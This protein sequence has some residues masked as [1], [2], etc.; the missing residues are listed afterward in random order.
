MGLGVSAMDF[1]EAAIP[2]R[3]LNVLDPKGSQAKTVT[4]ITLNAWRSHVFLWFC[5]NQQGTSGKL[6]PYRLQSMVRRE[7][8]QH[9]DGGGYRRRRKAEDENDTD[10][11]EE[12]G[13]GGKHYPSPLLM[14]VPLLLLC[15]VQL[16]RYSYTDVEQLSQQVL[17]LSPTSLHPYPSCVLRLGLRISSH[18]SSVVNLFLF[19]LSFIGPVLIDLN[20]LLTHVQRWAYTSSTKGYHKKSPWPYFHGGP[21]VV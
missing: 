1:C 2:F 7:R 17:T 9:E 13:Y 16:Y 4:P 8:S 21:L 18:A 15:H 20:S 5:V 12:T 14:H 3:P 10:Q 11:K 19:S 6:C